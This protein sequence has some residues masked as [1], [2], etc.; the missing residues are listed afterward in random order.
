MWA[1]GWSSY[2]LH[3]IICV[4]TSCFILEVLELLGLFLSVIADSTMSPV[5]PRPHLSLTVWESWLF[6]C[7]SCK[8]FMFIVFI[9]VVTCSDCLCTDHPP[10]RKPFESIACR[11]ISRSLLVIFSQETSQVESSED[12]QLV[13]AVKNSFGWTVPLSIVV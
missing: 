8:C 5:P 4:C 7:V 10:R 11:S 9:S 3:F 12:F 6:A 1:W 2:L 13:D